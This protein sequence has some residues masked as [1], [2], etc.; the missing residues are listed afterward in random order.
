MRQFTDY[1]VKLIKY[2]I[3]NHNLTSTQIARLLICKK[4]DIE[5]YLKNIN[6]V[7]SK[8]DPKKGRI[9]KENV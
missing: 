6:F 3:N 1:E 7:K 4:S 8:H 5:K 9:I 2:E